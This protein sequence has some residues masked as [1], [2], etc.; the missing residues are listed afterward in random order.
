MSTKSSYTRQAVQTTG[1]AGLWT[2]KPSGRLA[3]KKVVKPFASVTSNVTSFSATYRSGSIPCVLDHGSVKHRIK[4][5]TPPQ[6]VPAELVP[7]FADGLKEEAHPYCFI[8][9][10]GFKELL[11]S[12][13]WSEKAR[14]TLDRTIAPLKTSLMT[15]DL[16]HFI[17][18]L[19]CLEALASATHDALIPHLK[20][21]VAPVAPKAL[22]SKTR[23]RV[24]EAL[25]HIEGECGPDSLVHI[26]ARIPTYSTINF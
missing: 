9:P 16:D 12:P 23:D 25:Q 22:N 7:I 20:S 3:A 11:A 6:E 10:N 24:Y 19:S 15:K 18:N 13:G 14:M 4:W 2:E 21:I 5:T 17:T 8:A 1:S 26:K